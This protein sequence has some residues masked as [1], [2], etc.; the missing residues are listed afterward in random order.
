MAGCGL[1]AAP[2]LGIT[3]TLVFWAPPG[4]PG[5]RAA[6]ALPG[7]WGSIGAGGARGGA[8]PWRLLACDGPRA[9]WRLM[10]GESAART[11]PCRGG[12]PIATRSDRLRGAWAAARL[13]L[14]A[15]PR[16][17][18]GMFLLQWPALRPSSGRR[19]PARPDDG[20]ATASAGEDGA[21][22]RPPSADAGWRSRLASPIP[23]MRRGV[24]FA[25]ARPS[26]GEDRHVGQDDAVRQ[27]AAG[28]ARQARAAERKADFGEIYAAS[29][30][31]G[32]PSRPRAA[33]SAACRS[34][35]SIAR[36]TTT[37]PTGCG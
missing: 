26:P 1:D 22:W 34:A 31:S 2:T 6:A 36:C 17:R 30:R 10:A 32:R 24:A 18:R 16:P 25:S 7:P 21:S 5:P 35:R 37:S 8:W 3:A 13:G 29:R 20:D 9:A 33:S 12:K 4:P 19:G 23:L 11:S 14:G 28:H 27:C 15:L